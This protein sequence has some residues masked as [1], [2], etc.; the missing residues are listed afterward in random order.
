MSVLDD[1]IASLNGYLERFRKTGI[2]NRIGGVDAAGGAGRFQTISPVDKSIIC[3]VAHGNYDGDR[4]A[5]FSS[6]TV[7]RAHR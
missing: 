6:R 1:N 4:H 5:T 3:D 2:Q 7:S